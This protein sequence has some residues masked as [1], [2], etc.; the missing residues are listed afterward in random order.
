MMNDKY[1]K[2]TILTL[3]LAAVCWT[4][5]IAAEPGRLQLLFAAAAAIFSIVF[6]CF[7]AISIARRVNQQLS[8]YLVF[9]IA[10]GFLGLCVSAYA[11]YDLITDTGWFAG[12]V[13]TLLLIFVM[14]IILILLLADFLLY[15][16]HK[17]PK[18]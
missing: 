17:S 7:L 12:I 10:D 11:V 1:I 2:T 13:G 8:P 14:P 5:A 4:A 3:A 16:Q 18:Q 6:I 9:A 15:R